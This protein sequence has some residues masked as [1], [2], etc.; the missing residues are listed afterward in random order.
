MKGR[1]YQ[2]LLIYL[3]KIN[4]YYEKLINLDITCC[5]FCIILVPKL[6]QSAILM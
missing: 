5:I 2:V 1:H 4:N 3:I 6:L